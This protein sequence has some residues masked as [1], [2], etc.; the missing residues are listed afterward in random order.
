MAVTRDWIPKP[1]N[2]FKIF[3]D[4]ICKNCQKNAD[5]WGL[6]IKEVIDLLVLQ[7]KFNDFYGISSVNNNRTLIDI[8]N[9]RN[10]RKTYQAAIRNLA[11]K[12]L[13]TNALMSDEEK[14]RCGININSKG[15]TLSVI[16]KKSPLVHVENTGICT[17]KMAFSNPD[18]HK[19]CMPEGQNKVIVTFGFYMENDK[20]P[21]EIDCTLTVIFGKS[22][23][24]IVFEAKRRGMHFVGYARY[25]NTRKKVGKSATQFF[26]IVS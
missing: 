17:A 19:C 14:R 25:V 5:K 3:G 4:N 26:G 16:S 24:K 13:K 11:I 23:S 12:R 22:F 8:Q 10:A 6:I 7:K 20:I 18:N 21:V 9:T 2:K 1:I 15:Y